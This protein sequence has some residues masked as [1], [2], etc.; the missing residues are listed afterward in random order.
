MNESCISCQIR[1]CVGGRR[2][3]GKSTLFRE[4]ARR[5]RLGF[6]SIEGLGP[7]KGQTDADQLRNFGERLAEQ[8]RGKTVVPQSWPEAFHLLAKL[9]RPRRISV[10]KGLI[11]DGELAPAVRRGGYFDALIDI[12]TMI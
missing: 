11:Y 7:R 9:S 2:R 3:I 8:T 12:A 6:I 10:R 5:E 4:F 1:P